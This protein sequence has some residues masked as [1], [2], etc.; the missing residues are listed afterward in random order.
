VNLPVL[1][2]KPGYFSFTKCVHPGCEKL[3][4]GKHDITFAN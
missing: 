4:F 3:A 2:G 1:V